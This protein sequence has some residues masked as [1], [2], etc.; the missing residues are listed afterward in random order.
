MTFLEWLAE[1]HP[2]VHLT[3]LQHRWARML[4]AAYSDVYSYGVAAG[5]T[6]FM[7]L[8]IEYLH[9]QDRWIAKSTKAKRRLLFLSRLGTGTL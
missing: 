6:F 5:K 3:Q 8:W 2:E 4:E 1:R 9:D 7:R